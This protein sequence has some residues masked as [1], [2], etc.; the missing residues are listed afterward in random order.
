MVNQ[1]CVGELK[2]NC[3]I[4]PLP[5]DGGCIL[6]DPGGESG[7]IIDRLGKLRLEPRF[8]VLT[9]THFDHI[10]ALA[11][12]AAAYPEARVAVHRLEAARIGG[13]GLELQRRE[14]AA[15]A[16]LSFLDAFQGPLPE[17]GMLLE[18]G[19][20]VGPFTVFHLPGH[21]PGSIGLFRGDEKVLIS[22]DTLFCAGV[23]RTDLP[24]G[25]Q[26]Q[27]ELSLQR[28]FALDGDVQVYP[29]HGPATSI[30]RERNRYTEA[31][32]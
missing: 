1:L 32:P 9:H 18:E 31:A 17:A 21:S 20:T 6:A 28:L 11:G 26:A 24:G 8:I 15:L 3:W 7:R 29:G 2:T 25:D 30:R 27:L 19:D 10:G 12:I 16:A 23:G 13:G 5:Q 22:G 4:I 14:L